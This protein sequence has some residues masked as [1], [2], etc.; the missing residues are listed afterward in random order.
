MKFYSTNSEMPISSTQIWRTAKD[1][2]FITLGV[3]IY[4]FGFSSFVLPNNIVTGGLSGIC[5]IINLAT[6]FP[7]AVSSFVINGLLLLAALKVCGKQFVMSTIYGAVMISVMLGIMIPL[8]EDLFPNLLQEKFLCSVIGGI[9]GGIGIGMAF[10]HNGSSGGTDIIVAM[11]SKHTN[12][13]IGR[14][15]L[16]VDMCIICSGYFVTHNAENI[17]Y[18]LIFLFILSYMTDLMINSNRQ[19]TQFF[20]FSNKWQEIATA[21]NAQAHRGCTVLD[22]MGWYSKNDVKILLVMARKI[23]SVSIFRIVKSIDS[24]ALITQANVNGVYG[25][26]F[27]QMKV[28]VKKQQ[29]EIAE[30]T[31]S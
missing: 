5:T 7:I 14:T 30:T 27:D 21:I 20:I 26:G 1:F 25:N 16:Y 13:T 2:F 24:N 3:S 9:C 8:C 10:T 28:K 29:Q 15:L 17:V 23:E 19:A 4:A 22:G 11:I 31:K 6:G 12:L 18:G